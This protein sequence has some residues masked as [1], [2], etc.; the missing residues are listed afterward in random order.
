VRN[1]PREELQKCKIAKVNHS[2]LIDLEMN[3]PSTK[4]EKTGCAHMH[5]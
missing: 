5:W 4:R 1:V 2:I 3:E